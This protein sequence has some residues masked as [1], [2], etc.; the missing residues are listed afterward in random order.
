MIAVPSLLQPRV[1]FIKIVTFFDTI[2]RTLS[3]NCPYNAFVYYFHKQK[4]TMRSRLPQPKPVIR[5]S[6]TD[7]RQLYMV[8]LTD[9]RSVLHFYIAFSLSDNI[10][11]RGV[12]SWPIS[13][14]QYQV[15]VVGA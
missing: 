12:M 4:P 11:R 9:K 10:T 1:S 6:F 2:D 7:T 14:R 15:T 3:F 5:S 8:R 13:R